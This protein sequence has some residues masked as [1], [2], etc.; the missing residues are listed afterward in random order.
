MT[1]RNYQRAWRASLARS[2][3]FTAIAVAI[4]LITGLLPYT[5]LA[6]VAGYLVWHLSNLYRLHRWLT[7]NRRIARPKGWGI[8]EDIFSALHSRQ[9]ERRARKQ[10]LLKTIREFREA[11][12][13]LP[14]GI[15]IVDD[16]GRILWSNPGAQHLLGVQRP[17]DHGHRLQNLIRNPQFIEWLAVTDDQ[18]DGLLMHAPK[19]DAIMLR[20]RSFNYS[21]GQKLI[22]A[23][24]ISHIHRAD[25]MRK[26]FVANVSHEL[27][28]PLTVVAGYVE[29]LTEEADPEWHPIAERVAEQCQRMRAIVED[30]LTL[31]RLDAMAGIDHKE[32]VVMAPML[33]D[34]LTEAKIV[35]RDKHSLTANISPDIN[36]VG[37]AKE[38][39][40]AFMNLVTNAIRY[41]PEG[42]SIELSW[43]AT[44]DGAAFTVTD[45][46]LGIPEQHIPRL[47]ERFYR[48]SE[49][50]NRSNGGTGLGLAIVKHVLALHDADLIIESTVGEGS[51][52]TC[53]FGSDSLAQT[54]S[55]VKQTGS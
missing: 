46:G 13:A 50:R 20:I 44:S 49:D 25:A 22:I 28:T 35:D 41:T 52:F 29:A 27:R 12:Q 31:S 30:L 26:D 40:G 8:W 42:G 17:A 54:A 45:D 48:V 5:L 21:D 3:L 23:R 9:L 10:K 14:D 43:Q 19:D 4:G 1:S 15:L 34:L 33:N 51:S 24:D 2:I 11:T 47:T 7:T 53:Q 16:E 38:L 55:A 32:T 36:L 39:R 18:P 6:L 37:N